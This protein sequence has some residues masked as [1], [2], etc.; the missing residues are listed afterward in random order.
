MVT[1]RLDRHH[2][3]V[4]QERP[5][6]EPLPTRVSSPVLAVLAAAA[7]AV[8]VMVQ[9]RLSAA[10]IEP[11]GRG[12]GHYAE[13]ANRAALA[14]LSRC[15]PGGSLPDLVD[16]FDGVFPPL[17]HLVGL[18]TSAV[19]GPTAADLAPLGAL[20]LLLL[21]GGVGATAGRISGDARLG[22][23]AGGVTLLLPALHASSTRYY[24]DLPM[25][26]LL[27]WVP[28]PLL[29][30]HRSPL[31][32]GSAAGLLLAAACLTKWTAVPYG[33]AFA[34]GGVLCAGQTGGPAG[35]RGPRLLALA[36]AGAVGASVVALFLLLAG[37]ENS[38]AAMAAEAAAHNPTPAG[39]LGG[40]AERG[41]VALL[42]AQAF[43]AIGRF[44]LAR[45][46]FYAVTTPGAL[47]SPLLALLLLVPGALWLRRDR[48]G[49][50][51]VACV[52]LAHAGFGLLVMEIL[53]ERFM[54]SALPAAALVVA[55]A[56]PRLGPR[57]R[58]VWGVAALSVALWVA[59]DF[60]L[61]AA[62]PLNRPVEVMRVAPPLRSVALRGVG[63]ASSVQHRGWA[64][65]DEAPD[66][67]AALREALW[68]EVA[69]CRPT[70]VG[71]FQHRP[72]ILPGGDAD[73]LR[74]AAALAELPD[75]VPAPAV[76]LLEQRE[77]DEP[78]PDLVLVGSG[79]AAT[80]PGPAWERVR[81]VADPDGG[82]GVV[83][84]RRV[85]SSLCD[86]GGG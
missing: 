15:H 4:Q 79:A 28:F 12:A 6:D 52:V 47:L 42:T 73:W 40:V 31:R 71:V 69:T 48:A 16:A 19:L 70:A 49:L 38:L 20:W 78:A 82:P 81:E 1:G 27:W 33:A 65:R 53:D 67:R 84:L 55:V 25:T 58:V 86:A 5:P 36:L 77:P 66:D 37:P 57:L 30:A 2:G 10:P 80:S 13:H 60:H 34:L 3:G 83:M 41:P 63:L 32:A 35:P 22:W 72:L 17:L 43:T 39:P 23:L 74:Y 46:T 54:L 85:G 18:V 59:G 51:L 75:C 7:S 68:A 56:W 11:F 64:R 50:P 45:V 26:A 24:F 8:L 14:G 29:R 21:A 76:V 61:A 44:E 9:L 62:G